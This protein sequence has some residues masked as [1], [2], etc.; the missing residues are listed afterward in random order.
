[1]IWIDLYFPNN[2][3]PNIDSWTTAYT[4]ETNWLKDDEVVR[5][6]VVKGYLYQG[7]LWDSYKETERDVFINRRKN[8]VWLD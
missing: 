3:E 8:N 5:E 6:M 4:Y 1:M 2:V 7:R